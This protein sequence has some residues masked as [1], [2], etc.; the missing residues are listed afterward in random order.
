[1]FS[2]N[3]ANRYLTSNFSK[4]SVFLDRAAPASLSGLAIFK[5][6]ARELPAMHRYFGIS[7]ISLDQLLDIIYILESKFYFF[8]RVG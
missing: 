5:A 7:G 4:E 3:G 1:M 2:E 6:Q 8:S